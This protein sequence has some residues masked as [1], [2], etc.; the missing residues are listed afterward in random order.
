MKKNYLV[1]IALV[2]ALSS[3]GVDVSEFFVAPSNSEDMKLSAQPEL[4]RGIYL[5][6][7]M[8]LK[9]NSNP[10]YE[11]RIG[12]FTFQYDQKPDTATIEK[13]PSPLDGYAFDRILKIEAVRVIS[14]DVPEPPKKKE[15]NPIE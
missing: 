3:L 7:V 9:K 10:P 15:G 6:D 5:V 13:K 14:E 8:Y 11:D 4:I 12:P 1:Y 2:L